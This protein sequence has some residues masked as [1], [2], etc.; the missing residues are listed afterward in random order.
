MNWISQISKSSNFL[1]STCTKAAAAAHFSTSGFQ[2][3][4][5]AELRQ[6][7]VKPD[8]VGTIEKLFTKYIDT[9]Y[10]YSKA[11]GFWKA[12]LGST[13][14]KLVSIWEYDNLSQ[15]ADVRLALTKDKTW[16][17]EFLPNAMACL[18]VQEN[19]TMY[20]APWSEDLI[21]QNP[22]G[23]GIYE[24][25][26]IDMMNGNGWEN[27]LMNYVKIINSVDGCG[28]TG[29]WYN[30]IGDADQ[31]YVLWRYKDFESKLQAK[32]ALSE[33]QDAVKGFMQ[34]Y[35]KKHSMILLPQPWSLLK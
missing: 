15:R 16:V 7:S 5:V 18:D 14:N 35:K 25:N 30:E 6:Y 17:T 10:E 32:E 1:T 27:D 11:T 26:T 2:A 12:E 28:L 20:A 8:K 3:Q 34:S 24:L 22:E 29:V 19:C 13:I 33:N 31:V 23:V 9:R 4:K 21:E